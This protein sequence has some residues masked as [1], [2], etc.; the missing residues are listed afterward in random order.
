MGPTLAKSQPSV[1]ITKISTKLEG[2]EYRFD[3]GDVAP[4]EMSS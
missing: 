2:L 1:D 3:D 4:P